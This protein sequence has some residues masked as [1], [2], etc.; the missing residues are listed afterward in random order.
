M[1]EYLSDPEA[2]SEQLIDISEAK[3]SEFPLGCPVCPELEYIGV[4]DYLQLTIE[5]DYKILYR[6]DAP[7]DTAFITAFMRSKQSAEKLLVRYALL[8]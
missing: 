4:T 8:T 7:T 2:L 1:S 6:Y 5:Q 3:L